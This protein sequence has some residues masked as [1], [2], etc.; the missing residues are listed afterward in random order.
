LRVASNDYV[1]FTDW[2]IDGPPEL[3]YDVLYDG[4]DLPRWWPD[5]Y[6]S[7]KADPPGSKPGIGV[8]LRLHTRGWLPYTLRWTA[9]TVEANRPR[10]FT[11]VATGDFE[12]RGIW[13]LEP[14]GDKTRVT[15]DWRLRAEKPILRALSFALKPVFAWNHRWAMARG[16]ESLQR[17]VARRRQERPLARTA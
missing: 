11:L 1:F 15:F 14:D 6:L 5:V 10:T 2:V 12:G 4:E 3:V 7:A 17:E 13:T 9:E 16:Y 8:K